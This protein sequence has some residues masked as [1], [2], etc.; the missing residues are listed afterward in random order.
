[1]P[2]SLM[3][4]LAGVAMSTPTALSTTTEAEHKAPQTLSQYVREYFRDEP[5]MAD[6]AWCES[7]MRHID[8]K[9]GKIFRGSVNNDDI[10]VMQINTRYHL[11]KA[12]SMDI[13]LYSLKGNLEYAKYLYEKEGT[14]PW[15]SSRACWG[16]VAKK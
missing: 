11:E 6:I 7:R 1:M 16:K 15:A 10:G 9:T 5:I 2:L 8:E 13:D 14:T 3:I 12:E 4:L